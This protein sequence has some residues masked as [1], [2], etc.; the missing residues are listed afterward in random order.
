M[1]LERD[2]LLPDV[3][4]RGVPQHRQL[5][6]L[7]SAAQRSLDRLLPG[8]TDALVSGG[9]TRVRV[10]ADT[11]VHELGLR[12]PKRDLD[13][14]LLCAP[15]LLIE[16]TARGLLLGDPHVSVRAGCDVLDVHSS[17]VGIDVS[18]QRDWVPAD[19]V[20]DARGAG[21][22][23]AGE[24]RRDGVAFQEQ[25]HPVG[26]WYVTTTY[27]LVAAPPTEHLVWMVFPSPPHSRGG[28][29]SPLGDCL[30]HVSLSGR[31]RDPV[32]R[33]HKQVLEYAATLPDPVIAELLERCAPLSEPSLFRT[34]RAVWRR[35]AVADLPPDLL[36]IGD[37]YATLNPLF[38]QGMSVAS[39]E[40]VALAELVRAGVVGRDLQREFLERAA[41]I[42][43]SAWELGQLV[44]KDPADSDPTYTAALASLLAEDPDLHRSYVGIWHLITP[45]AVLDSDDVVARIRG[46]MKSEERHDGT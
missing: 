40:A 21:A 37:T 19:L 11:Y 13:L 5:H 36:P 18:G 43:S 26:Q 29:V 17:G 4:R 22:P 31:R 10:A 9:G 32:P 20:I 7:L 1:V 30:L 44:D 35:F 38:G 14:H 25:E 15:R 12:M 6:N 16:E 8:F 24:L 41:A 42:V 28:L 45:A 33:T 3:P 39:L 27:R 46:R 23:L 2:S 34:S